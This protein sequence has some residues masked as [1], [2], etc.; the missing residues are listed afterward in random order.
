MRTKTIYI[1]IILFLASTNIA[2]IISISAR[3]NRTEQA[4]D[5][6]PGRQPLENRMSFF[7]DELGLNEEQEEDAVKYNA[8]YNVRAGSITKDLTDLRHQI[9]E[10]MASE[11]PDKLELNRIIDEFGKRHS[12][13]KRETVD[14]YYQL[15]SI[16]DS[17]QRERLEFMFR[18]M[19]DPDGVI[20]GRGRGGH[21]RGR[22]FLEEG[23][24]TGWGRNRG[25]GRGR[26]RY[27]N[28]QN[29]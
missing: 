4:E 2:T 24:G 20:Y 5:L 7:W 27:G 22:Q 25:Y 13:L 23:P 16:C 15:Y 21:G 9:V 6:S 12:E 29:Y 19:L 17:N 26:G 18:D 10:E 28:S 14:F 1:I 8:D 11:E 3:K